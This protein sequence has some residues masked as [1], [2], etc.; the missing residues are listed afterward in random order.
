[1]IKQKN[2]KR[3]GY[4]GVSAP[5][6]LFF[7]LL[8]VGCGGDAVVEPTSSKDNQNANTSLTQTLYTEATTPASIRTGA[9]C[10]MEIPSLKTGNA[11]ALIVHTLSDGRLNYCIGYNTK[12]KANCWTAF[13]WY[14]GFSS[15]NKNWYRNNWKNGETF[16]GYGGNG[17]PFQPDPVLPVNMRFN[18][19]DYD[20]WRY[21]RGHL[22]G[23]ADRLN[24]KEANGQS[25]YM[26][27]IMPQLK[28][29]NEQGIWWNLENWLR[30]TY[31]T[32][33]F[34]DTLYVVKGGTV[35]AGNYTMVGTNNQL[36]CPKYFYMAI[37]A[38]AQKY[39][40]SNGGYYAI[41]FWMEHKGNTDDVSSK[42]AISIDELERRTGIDFFC[43]LPDDI[44]NAVERSFYKED[45]RLK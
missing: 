5:L 9:M 19:G 45:W 17:D 24:S 6:F 1:M 8:L 32:S 21:Q 12:L 7:L 42:Y 20:D 36:V 13:K 34:R 2:N 27:N 15:N 11:D 28:A 3:C 29:F 37:L 14:N 18:S 38:Y 44:E 31:D 33:S 26:S 10:G 25:F 16:N 30:S 22:L 35:S 43:N 41:A 23:S 40:K 4:I 39:A